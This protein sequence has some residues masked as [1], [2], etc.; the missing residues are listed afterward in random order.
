MSV[1][2]GVMALMD[3]N[4]D[5]MLL[6]SVKFQ[7]KTMRTY[8]VDYEKVQ[9]LDDVIN[10]L[11]GLNIRFVSAEEDIVPNMRKYLKESD[12]E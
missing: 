9:T 4:D 11:M 6:P 12:A 3:N 7:Q 5:I 1:S 8:E 10:V 2:I